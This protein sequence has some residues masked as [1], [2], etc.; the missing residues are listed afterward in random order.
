MASAMTPD[1]T[2]AIVRLARGDIAPEDTTGSR[3]RRPAWRPVVTGP[4]SR[5]GQPFS[6]RRRPR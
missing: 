4:A 6:P 3:H 1:P 5:P 2:V